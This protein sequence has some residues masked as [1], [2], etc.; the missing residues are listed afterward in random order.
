MRGLRGAVLS[1]LVV[2][3]ASHP[4]TAHDHAPPRTVVHAPGVR[5]VGDL[6]SQ[7]WT[8]PTTS[9][10]QMVCGQGGWHFPKTVDLEEDRSD[11]SLRIRK[12]MP[13]TEFRLTLWTL[14]RSTGEPRGRGE[15]LLTTFTPAV[16]NG[17]VVQ[18]VGFS[19]PK[20]HRC[21]YLRAFGVWKD[22]DGSGTDQDAA[23]TFRLASP[24]SVRR[25]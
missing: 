1:M 22:E 14:R 7:C 20:G 4:A 2:L 16:V 19:L 24:A 18:E 21:Y 11:L 13:P 3:A 23:W 5:Q 15:D 25:C 9:G 12:A 10:T 17:R 6:V 8:Q